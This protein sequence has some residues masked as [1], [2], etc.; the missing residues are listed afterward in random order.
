MYSKKPQVMGES[1]HEDREGQHD[2]PTDTPIQNEESVAAVWMRLRARLRAEVGEDVFNSWFP[3]MELVE[4]SGGVVHLS[5]PTKF[6]KS[7]VNSH[8]R[9]KLRRLFQEQNCGVET[10]FSAACPD[11]GGIQD[12]RLPFG[13]GFLLP[14]T[15]TGAKQT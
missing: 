8:Y 10:D 2:A 4:A 14:S 13:R 3:R 15:K 7:W 9:E 11:C 5:V 6:L 1:F 12:V